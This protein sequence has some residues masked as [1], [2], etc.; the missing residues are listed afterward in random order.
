MDAEYILWRIDNFY[1]LKEVGPRPETHNL[2]K[3]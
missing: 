1:I 2:K 3:V